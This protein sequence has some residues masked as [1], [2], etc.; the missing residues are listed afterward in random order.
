MHHRSFVRYAAAALL[1]AAGAFSSQVTLAGEK[2]TQTV[3]IVGASQFGPANA[4]GSIGSVRNSAD[5]TQRIS[6]QTWFDGVNHGGLCSAKNAAGTTLT[7][8]T[9]SPTDLARIRG[10]SGQMLVQF[11]EQGG[12][13]V[14]FSTTTSSA[15]E[16]PVN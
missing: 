7:C 14:G 12:L 2:L 9:T 11:Y 10:M 8:T 3:S 6:C 1:C 13:C 16:V 15:N 5:N 4:K